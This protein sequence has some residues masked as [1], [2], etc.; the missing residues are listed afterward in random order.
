MVAAPNVATVAGVPERPA[1][2]FAAPDLWRAWLA[3]H[4]ATALELWVGF[5]KRHT[6]QPSMRWRESVDQ[7]LCFGWIDGVRQ[8]IDDDRYRIRFTPRKP[9]S[10]WSAV[11]L[12]R[13]EE[14]IAAGLVGEAG[15]TAY[16]QRVV[17]EEPVYSY[18]REPEELPEA[19]AAQLAAVPAAQ[20][21]WDSRPPSYRRP[22]TRWVLSAKREETRDRRMAQLVADCAAGRPIKPLS[23]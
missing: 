15:L 19:Y 21:W 13:I 23:Y 9:T 5:H 16:R 6:S 10:I 22:A 4:H 14:L 12:A 17:R 18:E 8:R 1:T 2:F 20:A 11:N 7:A 3:D